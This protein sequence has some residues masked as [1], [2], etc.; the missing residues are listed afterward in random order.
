MVINFRKFL[1]LQ[2]RWP[3]FSDLILYTQFADSPIWRKRA[4]I[5]CKVHQNRS[6]VS[7]VIHILPWIFIFSTIFNEK[8]RYSCNWLRFSQIKMYTLASSESWCFYLSEVRVQ[9]V[10]I[11]LCKNTFQFFNIWGYSRVVS[12]LKIKKISG[13]SI[14]LFLKCKNI[15]WKFYFLKSVFF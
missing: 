6:T 7:K 8:M 3:F 11:N 13:N 5:R 2:T 4:L 9:R 10:N 15:F 1:S 14:Y 12:S